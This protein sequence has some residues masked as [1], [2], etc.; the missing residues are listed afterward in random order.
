MKKKLALFC[1]LAACAAFARTPEEMKEDVNVITNRILAYV[2]GNMKTNAMRNFAKLHKLT[3]EELTQEILLSIDAMKGNPQLVSR[4]RFGIDILGEF[5]TTNAVPF[6]ENLLHDGNEAPSA[7]VGALIKCSGYSA[8][9]FNRIA[10]IMKEERKDDFWFKLSV[11][12]Q[13]SSKF[14]F[15]SPSPEI[16]KNMFDFLMEATTF[17]TTAGAG[18]LDGLLCREYPAFRESLPRLRMAQ[19]LAEKE[20]AGGV[21]DGTYTALARQLSGSPGIEN[22]KKVEFVPKNLERKKEKLDPWY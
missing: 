7:P 16:Q 6:L 1:C 18:H 4:R 2:H 20:K 13:L 3:K 21:K 17:E 10:G 22:R 19:R 8:D 11:Y 12:S 14:E 5:G 15:G 9:G